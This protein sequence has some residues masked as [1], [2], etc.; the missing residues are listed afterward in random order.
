MKIKNSPYNLIESIGY[1]KRNHFGINTRKNRGIA[2]YC[3]KSFTL[4]PG[5]NPQVRIAF[6]GDM[7]DMAGK[8]ISF[9]KDIK[10]FIKNC[11]YLIGNFEATI[12]AEKGPPFSQRHSPQTLDALADLFIPQKIYLSIANNHAGDFGHETWLDSVR[13]IKEKGFNVFGTKQKPYIE[14]DSLIRITTGTKWTNQPCDY[15]AQLDNCLESID[16]KCINILY[17]HWGYELEVFPR[18]E[19]V[20]MA[21]NLIHK[22]DAIIG[23]HS[24]YPQAVTK[25]KSDELDDF[26][27]GLVAYSLGDFCV[28]E[29]YDHYLYGIILKLDIGPTAQG[30]IQIGQVEW[31]FTTCQARNETNLETILTDKIPY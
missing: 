18:P 29:E 17:P 13:Q 23:H 5:I 30:R 25:V 27:Y 14:L 10:A 20:K 15:I 21:K 31:Q 26:T 16:P 3:E 11:D 7:M 6:I 2:S 28:W 12:T 22:F 9:G 24:H 4:N 1:L 19:T 8:N